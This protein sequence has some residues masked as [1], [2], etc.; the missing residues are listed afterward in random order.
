MGLKTLSL[1]LKLEV[2]KAAPVHYCTDFTSTVIATV[3]TYGRDIRRIGTLLQAVRV[4]RD[5]H[6]LNTHP[7]PQP[8]RATLSD[9]H[10]FAGKYHT[11][12]LLPSQSLSIRIIL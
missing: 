4:V 2:F 6:P 11:R 8:T 1:S 7:Y 3:S 5:S 10:S 12:A 9:R